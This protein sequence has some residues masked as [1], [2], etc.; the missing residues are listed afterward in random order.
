LLEPGI[1]ILIKCYKNPKFFILK[2]EVDFKNHNLVAIYFE[3]PFDDHLCFKKHDNFLKT[4]KIIE[5]FL[6][7]W[8][9]LSEHGAEA[10]GGIFDKLEP[11]PE[12]EP[13]KNEP[14]PQH[15]LD[16][17]VDLTSVFSLICLI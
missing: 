12:L 4:M 10:G 13:D 11:E 9:K 2:F 7:I 5:F 14:A 3:E 15:S 6:T 1:K 16:L 17:C 8:G